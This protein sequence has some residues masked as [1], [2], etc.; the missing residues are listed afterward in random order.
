[1]PDK[2]RTGLA[3]GILTPPVFMF[4]FYAVAFAQNLPFANFLEQLAD[5]H[6][7][8]ALMAFGLLGNLLPFFLFYK[9]KA[10]RAANGVIGAT[11]ALGSIIVYLKL[12]A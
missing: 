10:D 1:M 7:F 5:A 11:L 8:S 12:L 3:A 2:L 9:A 4:G 6:R